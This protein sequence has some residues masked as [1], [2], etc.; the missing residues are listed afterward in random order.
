MRR[1][2]VV[3]VAVFVGVLL[4]AS[5]CANL[6]GLTGG[7][8]PSDASDGEPRS[9]AA[10]VLDAR[11]GDARPRDASAGDSRTIAFDAT[12][13]AD[14]GPRDAPPQM[15]LE[16]SAL[17]ASMAEVGVSVDAFVAPATAIVLFGGVDPGDTWMWDGA[18]WS[19]LT[20]TSPPGRS[21]V[22][23][24]RLGDNA[25]FFGGGTV[26]DTWTWGGSAWTPNG[27]AGPSPRSGAAMARFGDTL[28]LFGGSSTGD[29]SNATLLDD[30]WTWDGT[31]WTQVH[32]TGPAA[33]SDA[34]MTTLG[35]KV[36]LFGGVEGFGMAFSDTWT[37]NGGG[38]TH[39]Q[40][41]G[42]GARSGGAMA[43][44][45]SSAILFGGANDEGQLLSDTWAWDGATWA[46]VPTSVAPSGR[47]LASMATLGNEVYLFGGFNG[48]YDSD[49]WAWNGVEWSSLPVSGP[50]AR[51]GAAMVAY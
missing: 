9:D 38:W 7:A 1:K 33:R 41:T 31:T 5:G 29:A 25:V 14:T 39:E 22:A 28:V 11:H 16:G 23:G 50:S 21:G 34:S 51:S 49:T 46:A 32:V 18:A 13:P 26:S 40:A 36:V 10:Q 47:S 3:G 24:A 19:A 45:G 2:R 6:D 12:H 17:D 43:T 15:H 4:V 27:T 44:L 35:N 37:W 42:P 30:T 8:P 48:T 20:L